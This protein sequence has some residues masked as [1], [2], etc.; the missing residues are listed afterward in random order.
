MSHRPKYYYNSNDIIIANIGRYELVAIGTR[1][2]SVCV[3]LIYSIYSNGTILSLYVLS[4]QSAQ[5][6]IQYKV[7]EIIIKISA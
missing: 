2:K 5:M 4:C 6:T 3:L 7:L 1:S